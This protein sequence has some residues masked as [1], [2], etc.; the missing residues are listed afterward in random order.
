MKKYQKLS[1]HAKSMIP[2]PYNSL[3]WL[4]GKDP[5]VQRTFPYI[6]W[7]LI[8]PGLF[9]LSYFFIGPIFDLIVPKDLHPGIVVTGLPRLEQ[10]LFGGIVHRLLRPLVN[11]VFDL[12]CGY[13]YM[14]H[15]LW[16]T[17]FP[18]YLIYKYK[19][20][21]RVAYFY[22]VLAVVA[23]CGFLTMTLYPSAP[24]WFFEFSVEQGKLLPFSPITGNCAGMARADHIFGVS[25]FKDF[26]SANPIV[27]GS[28][29]SMHIAWPLTATLFDIKNGFL[30]FFDFLIIFSAL[31]LEHHFLIDLICG[32]LYVAFVA[33]ILP[34][35]PCVWKDSVFSKQYYTKPKEKKIFPTIKRLISNFNHMF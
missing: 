28:W 21:K 7:R 23:N 22:L 9:L 13:I 15:Y 3:N 25:W 10:L 27:F 18:I 6:S 8:L 12:I 33:M 4:F 5:L 26:Y 35:P 29:P 19:D 2:N 17:V 31:Y 1:N 34:P 32:V 11:P 20:P 14:T 24:S 30:W 16:P